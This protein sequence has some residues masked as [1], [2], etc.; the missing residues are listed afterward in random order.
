MTYLKLLSWN[1]Q[2][3]YYTAF[4]NKTDPTSGSSWTWPWM[5][6]A[7]GSDHMNWKVRIVPRPCLKS[8]GGG[9]QIWSGYGCKA[10]PPTGWGIRWEHRLKKMSGHWVR[11]WFLAFSE[12]KIQKYVG[13]SGESQKFT[14]KKR[15]FGW[16]LKQSIVRVLSGILSDAGVVGMLVPWV[17]Q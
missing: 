9:S 10:R 11:A 6:K 15:V 3:H 13:S 16:Y 4:V 1:F 5:L 7:S 12:R 2:L 8:R 14:K 17:V